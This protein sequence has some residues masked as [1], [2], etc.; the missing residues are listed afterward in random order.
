[1]AAITYSRQGDYLLP[2][3]TIPEGEEVHLGKYAYLR[4]QYLMKNRYGMY[5]NLLTAG[6]LNKHL[7]QTEEEA[8]TRMEI[9]IQQMAE[10]EGVTEKLKTR[11]QMESGSGE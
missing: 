3:L 8:Q 5:L 10:K 9:L 6:T 7:L 11:D 2:N 4:K 1:M